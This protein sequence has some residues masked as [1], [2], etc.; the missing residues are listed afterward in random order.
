MDRDLALR[1]DA[2]ETVRARD[3]QQCVDRNLQTAVGAVLE[4]HRGRQS[5]R[6]FAMGLRFGGAGADGAPRDQVA[7]VLGADR[8]ECL[9]AG[10]QAKLVDVEQHLARELQAFLDG[11]GVVHARIVDEPLPA[12]GGAGLLEVDPH[13]DE[14]RVAHLVGHGLQAT[15]VVHGGGR[16]VDRAGSHHHQQPRVAPVEDLLDRLAAFPDRALGT[17]RERQAALDFLGGGEHLLLDDVDVVYEF[18]VHDR[19]RGCGLRQAPVWAGD[20]TGLLPGEKGRPGAAGPELNFRSP[21][22]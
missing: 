2:E 22:P 1:V 4:S 14:D 11:E 5:A 13:H 17:L 18:L 8:I 15:C 20:A 7:E 21:M 9:G 16:V 12:R 19:I 3:R 6:H 10:R